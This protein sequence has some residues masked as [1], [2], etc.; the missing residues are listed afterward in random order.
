MV[1]ND[2]NWL[3]VGEDSVHQKCAANSNVL[4]L[5]SFPCISLHC[6]SIFQIPAFQEKRQHMST[7]KIEDL[8]E[9]V[10]R[11]QKGSLEPRIEVLINRI[12]EVQQAKKKAGEELGEAQTVWDTLQKELDS[13]HE[14]KE[15]LKDIL[16]KKQETLRIMRLHCQEKES[17]AE[18]KHS[19]LQECKDRISF[20]NSQI[21]N[22]KDKL[23]RLRLDFEKQL[24][25][26]MSQHKDLLEFHK[27]EHLAKETD[28]LDSSKEQ[29]LKEEK[30]IELKLEDV[31]H[32]LFALCGPE[33]SSSFADGLF[34]RSH[35]AAAAMQMFREENQKAEEL[36]EA[37][38]QHHQQ[39]QERCQ[40][41]QQKR[42]MLKEE[43]EKHGLQIL[44]QVQNMQDEG[45]SSQRMAS[46][47]PLGVHEE[48]VQ[49]HPPSRT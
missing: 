34:L 21:D 35:E 18:R 10:K 30:L 46:P 29:L 1:E 7:E 41:L 27:P 5:R 48:K 31:K 45:D 43:V 12:N 2:R 4:P 39:L 36:L 23:R 28:D 38:A 8:M 15:R 40:E 3:F 33:E 47:K 16:N 32:R 49:E 9:M 20:L 6:M 11:L 22:E 37:A 26:L 13:L 44:S 17:E 19:M 25:T 24:E 14:E 42:Q